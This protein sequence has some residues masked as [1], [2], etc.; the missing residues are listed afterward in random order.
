MLKNLKTR[1]K[2]QM[3]VVCVAP[4]ETELTLHPLPCEG[5]TSAGSG[6][7]GGAG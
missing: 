7:Q 1:E 3:R 6:G 4:W 2:Q 5:G